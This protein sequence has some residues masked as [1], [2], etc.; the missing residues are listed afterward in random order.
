MPDKNDAEEENEDESEG[1]DDSAETEKPAG[2]STG[3]I[4][5]AAATFFALIILFFFRDATGWQKF[6]GALLLIVF[7]T[8]FTFVGY[9]VGN[10]LRKA[11]S[12]LFVIADS[13]WGLLWAK[14]FW[15]LGPQLI[16]AVIGWLASGEI[17]Y[18]VL[19]IDGTSVPGANPNTKNFIN[20]ML[21]PNGR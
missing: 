10:A 11:L 17:I 20:F 5:A 21:N 19:G 7:C 13:F 2:C 4:I 3:G 6:G 1:V 14:V 8:L 15:A 9:T 16:G 18:Y 12:P